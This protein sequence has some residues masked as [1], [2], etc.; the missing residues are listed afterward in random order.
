LQD[1]AGALRDTVVPDRQR[2]RIR[3][4]L[5]LLVL[6]LALPFAGY[7]AFSAV[8]EARLERAHAAARM[9]GIAQ[10]TAARLDDHINDI[11]SVLQ[12]LSAF[13]SPDPARTA[14]NDALLRSLSGKVPAHIDNLSV[15][16][17]TGEDVGTLEPRLRQAAKGVVASRR[18]FK[19]ALAGADIS[20]QAPLESLATGARISAF[21]LPTI[22]D[23]KVVGIVAAAVRLDAL[24][25]LLSA[26]A[27]LPASAIV[28]VIDQRGVVLARSLDPEHWI[29]KTL[30]GVGPSSEDRQPSFGADGV[31]DGPSADG[32]ARIA[33]FASAHA[34][35]WRVYVGVPRDEALAPVYARLRNNLLTAGFMLLAG[36]LLA[37]IVGEGI[38]SP[39]RA[40]VEDATE[41]GAG[42]LMHRSRAR[43]GGEVAMLAGTLNAMAEQLQGRARELL[44]TQEQLRQVTNNLPA[45]ISYIDADQR[46]CFANRVY[47]TWLGQ[48]PSEL[49]GKSLLELYGP[50]AYEGFKGHVQRALSGERVT[51]GRELTTVQGTRHVDVTAVPDVEPGGRVK[52]LFVMMIDAT[53]RRDAEAAL[54]HSEQ[55]LR[56][57]ADNIP[58]LVT[59]VDR[60]QRYRFVNA[61]L[62]NIFHTD[63]QSLVGRTVRETGG[64][65]LYAEIAPHVAAALRGEEVVFQG[66][67]TIKDRPYHYQSTYI[68]DLDSQGTVRGYY[69]MTFD[70]S[71]LKETQHRLDML[72]SID[73]LTG[74]P[75][76]RQFDERLRD[77]MARTR[78][79]ATTMAVMFLDI[80]HFKS[81]NDTLGHGVGDMVLKEFGARLQRQ[82]RSTDVVARLAGDEFVVLV[83]GMRDAE[84]LTA[85]AGK[86]VHAVRPPL[87]FEG[88][89]VPITTSLGVA[90]YEGDG[91][92]PVELLAAADRALYA[93]KRQGRDRFSLALQESA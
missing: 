74:L 45:L 87:V 43:G 24:Q 51:Y 77:A 50:E 26:G 36:L 89:S 49:V 17:T 32:I 46:F 19:E 35:N 73:T 38:A 16:T 69:A 92:S 65:T 57:V 9:F 62:G 52:G 30:P 58:A 10:I 53:A 78:R 60:E 88:R 86:I 54:L 82:M 40:L 14:D 18:F 6:A 55:R 22:R 91:R 68:P 21:G 81:I 29:G 47:E 39:L 5:A 64:E 67:W 41:L 34:V 70:I 28:T 23:G 48:D 2:F 59:Y 4:R 3:T 31:R 93:A 66:V 83:E 61:Y 75:N 72:A 37:G 13:V 11:R 7:S 8:E 80:D 71:A 63:P 85:L 12:V 27:D 25:G 1:T 20:A 79:S 42:N 84:E 76:R 15:W 56:M 90:T 44:S 33:G